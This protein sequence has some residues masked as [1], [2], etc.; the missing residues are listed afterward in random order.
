M[1]YNHLKKGF[2]RRK[3]TTELVLIISHVMRR[4]YEQV[5]LLHFPLPAIKFNIFNHGVFII[6]TQ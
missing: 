3:R 2:N 1:D 4:L 5:I 6:K